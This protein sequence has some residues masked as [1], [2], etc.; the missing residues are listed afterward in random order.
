M[1]A[2]LEHLG[3]AREFADTA[4]TVILAQSICSPLTDFLKPTLIVSPCTTDLGFYHRLG[5]LLL[6]LTY[7]GEY[8]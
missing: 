6:V 1:L 3:G 7:W 2:S 4:S 8:G 5:W